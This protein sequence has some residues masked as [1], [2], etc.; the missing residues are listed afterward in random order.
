MELEKLD[1]SRTFQNVELYTGLSSL[2][3]LMAARHSLMKYGILSA[4][5]HFGKSGGEEVKHR[6]EIEDIVKLLE[7]ENI[8]DQTGGLSLLD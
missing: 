7:I 1:I 2:D 6:R 3:N 8:R 5:F 4:L